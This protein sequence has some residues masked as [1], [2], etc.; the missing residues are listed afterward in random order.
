METLRRLH[1]L[2][3][4][5]LLVWFALSVGIA[6]AAP[7]LQPHSGDVVCSGSGALMPMPADSGGTPTADHDHDCRLCAV[8]GAPPVFP[9][10]AAHQQPADTPI[11]QLPAPVPAQEPVPFQQRGP[12]LL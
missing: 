11:L 10:F 4:Q 5:L 6:V 3:C 2:T 8:I 12:P 7:I 9:G 1:R